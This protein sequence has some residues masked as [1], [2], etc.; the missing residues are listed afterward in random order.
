MISSNKP[1][2]AGSSLLLGLLLC[3]PSQ[4]AHADSGL[5]I[6]GSVGSAGI[7][8][9]DADL[10]FDEDDAAWKVFAGYNFDLFIIDLAVEGGYVNFGS[11]SDL[12]A[13][14]SGNFDVNLD[15][16]GLSAF[17]LAGLELGPI[18]IFAKAGL[19]D[20]SVDSTIDSVGQDEQDGTDP[21]YGVGVRF[22]LWSL[23]FRA[24]YEYFDIDVD[25][26]DSSDIDMV[27][28]G[29]VWTF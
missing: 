13:D 23:E 16:E 25:D 24:E 22:S 9:E 29:V 27:S 10:N 8:L 6:G 15:V 26:L 3:T 7:N 4:F 14:P 28:V 20:W 12:V 2:F 11:P 21:A 19:V 1:L 17:A 5:Y 18:G